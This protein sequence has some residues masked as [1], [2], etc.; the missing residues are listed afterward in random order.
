MILITAKLLTALRFEV[1]AA[2]GLLLTRDHTLVDSF[3]LASILSD[4]FTLLAI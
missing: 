1:E 2:C 4:S 3:G